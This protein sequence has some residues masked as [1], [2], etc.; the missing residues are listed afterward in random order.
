MQYLPVHLLAASMVLGTFAT[1]MP[2]PLS[3]TPLSRS[4][5]VCSQKKT[6]EKSVLPAVSAGRLGSS[7][8]RSFMAVVV[9]S[10]FLR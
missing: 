4:H 2:L 5:L 3:G 10:A 6:S 8:L 9:S 1:E 7:I